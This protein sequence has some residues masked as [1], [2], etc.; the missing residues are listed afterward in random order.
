MGGKSSYVSAYLLAY[1]RASRLG[2]GRRLTSKS[3]LL[4]KAQG[5]SEIGEREAAF[6]IWQI[7][8][9]IPPLLLAFLP[10]L[11]NLDP[12]CLACLGCVRSIPWKLLKLKTPP[13]FPSFPLPTFEPSSS[14]PIPS[15]CAVLQQLTKRDQVH[16]A[17]R[18]MGLGKTFV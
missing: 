5:V 13:L 16:T 6:L 12:A 3:K 14:P 17:K 4:S 8:P 9:S 15:P 7:P 2:G 18:G 11:A 1:L 10:S